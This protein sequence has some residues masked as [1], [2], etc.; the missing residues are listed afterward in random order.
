MPCFIGGEMKGLTHAQLSKY[1]LAQNTFFRV[2]A[3]NTII[4]NKR[5]AGDKTASYYEFK[6]GEH[7]L[8][9]Q[10]QFLLTQND[11]KNANLYQSIAKV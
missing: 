9:K 5:V 3:Y 6:E 11:P 10:G 2:E 7:I 1:S 4:R 8:Y